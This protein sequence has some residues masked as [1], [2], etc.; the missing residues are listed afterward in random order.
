MWFTA[1]EMIGYPDMP[2]SVHKVRAKLDKL[3]GRDEQVFRQRTGS[4]A[5]EYHVSCLPKETQEFIYAQQ[6]AEQNEKERAER[7]ELAKSIREKHAQ[8]KASISPDEKLAALALM[9][10]WSKERQ[11]RCFTRY[12][13]MVACEEYIGNVAPMGVGRTQATR[14]FIEM[15]NAKS[16]PFGDEVYK[17]LLGSLSEA[18]MRRWRKKYREGGIAS[19]DRMTNSRKGQFIIDTQPEMKQFALAF[20]TEFPHAQGGKLLRAIETEFKNSGLRIPC[21][22]STQRWLNAWK[23]D[24]ASLFESIHNPDA[25]KNKYMSGFGS[26]SEGIDRLNQLW[27][28]DAT[29]ADLQI[30]LMDGSKRRYHITALIDVYS[31]KPKL[32]VT[33]TPRTESNAALLRRAILD[34]GKPWKVKIDNGS[35]YVSRGMMVVLDALGIDYEICPPFSPW[36]KPHIER[37]FRHFSHDLLEL[38]P[39]FIGHN[40]VER[41]AI[42]ARKTFAERLMKKDEVIDVT[43][44]PEE[45]QQFCD[46]WVDNIYMHKIHSSLSATP[47]E[48]VS[49]Y[50]G[51]IQRISNER[52]LDQLLAVPTKGGVRTVTKGGLSV[53]GLNYIDGELALHIGERVQIRYDKDDLGQIVVSTL[54]GEFIC[55]AVCP[56]YLGISRQSI[57]EEAKQLQRAEI[58]RAKK[59]IQAAKRKFK[60][61]DIAD[62]IMDDAAESAG[63][64]VAMPTRA[65]EYTNTAIQGA[66]EA[67]DAL[68]NKESGITPLTQAHMDTLRD[69]IRDDQKQDETEEDRFRRWLA[70]NDKVQAGET[71]DEISEH[72]KKNYESTSEFKGRYMVW[73]DFGDSAFR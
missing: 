25:W 46:E 50:Q 65:T 62:R 45:L 60:V 7:A 8:E 53:D 71:L 9:S 18:S 67:S 41:K 12:E 68:E 32:L 42:E 54:E 39:G 51:E 26:A 70:L 28:L 44:T 34:M 6:A 31:R 40:V 47:F 73:E 35:D 24:N 64:L 58:K 29:P 16:L 30:T 17:A 48:M 56:E 13:V 10:G 11:N 23:Q 15:F 49:N 21:H 43:I 27:E 2:S 22:R 33:E 57:A 14:D 72:W 61:R 3:S 63:K 36:K 1:K 55:V 38:K 69:L 20:I 59:E 66:A 37:F 19:L 5:F 52:A 4:K